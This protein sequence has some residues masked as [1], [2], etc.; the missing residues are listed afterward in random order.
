MS[1]TAKAK[2]DINQQISKMKQ[3]GIGFNVVSE[4]EAKSFLSDNTYYFKLKSFQKNYQKNHANIYSNLE[5]AYLRDFSTIDMH[6]RKLVLS[7][8]LNIEHFLKVK[9]NN[10]ISANS[11]EDGYSIVEKFFKDKN[12]SYIMS[13]IIKF[14]QSNY[15]GELIN[16]YI[17]GKTVNINGFD[18][19]TQCPY[20]VLFEIL[21]FGDFIRFYN[22]YYD[23]YNIANPVKN[24]LFPVKCL[25]NAGAHNNCILN[26]LPKAFHPSFTPNKTV[27]SIVSKTMPIS[28]DSRKNCL[29]VPVLH[30]FAALCIVFNMI[31]TSTPVKN[32]T[33]KDFKDFMARLDRNQAYYAK[34]AEIRK[35]RTFFEK[36]L[37][38]F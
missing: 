24:L 9:L 35:M 7:M 13:N 16:K 34:N 36:L 4:S 32:H 37:D 26:M 5:F 38:I 19:P 8:V 12:N 28:P 31:V 10:D 11:G 33:V 29:A 25:R 6:F 14:S 21:S 1:I 27:S 15:S 23:A 2:L 18:V 20:W 17:T 22:F 30:D 3:H